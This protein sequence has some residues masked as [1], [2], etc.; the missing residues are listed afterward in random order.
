MEM[1]IEATAAGLGWPAAADL[2][3][4]NFEL[5][6]D[7]LWVWLNKAWIFRWVGDEEGY[8]RVVA[9]V[10]AAAPNGV[11]TNN[12]HWPIEIAALGSYPFS[13]EQVKQLDTMIA[14][15]EVALPGRSPDQQA[16][17]YRAIGQMQLRLGRLNQCL[18]ASEKFGQHTSPEPYN[19]F[20]R[21]SCLHQLGRH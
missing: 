16:A 18:A 14:A 11:S 21:A 5:F 20:I 4:E 6:P 9:K 8:R 2:C 17:G 3:R 10:L 15:L 13:E 7:S 1:L 19:L 12:Q